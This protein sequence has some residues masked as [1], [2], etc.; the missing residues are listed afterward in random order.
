M[1][2]KVDQVIN[3]YSKTL[4]QNKRIRHPKIELHP[5]FIK[6]LEKQVEILEKQGMDRKT[7]L[8]RMQRALPFYI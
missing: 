1:S 7:I 6:V 2:D 5:K 3:E 8:D 4:L